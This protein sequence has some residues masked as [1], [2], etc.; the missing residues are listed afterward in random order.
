MTVTHSTTAPERFVVITGGPGSGRS[1]LIERL[2]QAGFARTQEAGRGVI[3]AQRA[4]GGRALPWADRGL[5]A[6]AVRAVGAP[7]GF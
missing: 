4:V 6:E 2:A 7:G 3:Q 5:F 1:A